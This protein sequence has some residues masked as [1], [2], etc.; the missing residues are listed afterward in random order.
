MKTIASLIEFEIC[1]NSRDM[2]IDLVDVT[3]W[4]S[5]MRFEIRF[6]Q[7]FVVQL[8]YY[9]VIFVFEDEYPQILCLKYF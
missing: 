8:V 4:L 6:L 7:T 5:I 3:L 1:G 9:L 2:E